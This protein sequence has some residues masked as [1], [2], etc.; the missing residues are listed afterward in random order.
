MKQRLSMWE[1][2]LLDLFVFRITNGYVTMKGY[3]LYP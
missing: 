1:E 3:N 2:P